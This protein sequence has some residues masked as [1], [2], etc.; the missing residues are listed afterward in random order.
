MAIRVSPVGTERI[1]FAESSDAAQ[2]AEAKIDMVGAEPGEP[3]ATNRD[4]DKGIGS[5]LIEW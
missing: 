3:Q 2:R 1:G 5:R 4:V